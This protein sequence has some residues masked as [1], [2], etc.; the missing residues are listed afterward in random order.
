MT[1]PTPAQIE[2]AAKAIARKVGLDRNTRLIDWQQFEPDA[3]AAL[4][5]AAQV[6][7]V[8][9][10]TLD[11]LRT[12]AAGLLADGIDVSKLSNIGKVE[13][14]QAI[15]RVLALAAAQVGEQVHTVDNE[16]GIMG[17]DALAMDALK[18]ATIERC[19]QVVEQYDRE[20]GHTLN[21]DIAAAIRK[22]KDEP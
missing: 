4:T 1:A 6:G 15:D 3:K 16:F 5:A 9:G 19:A 11:D 10:E 20:R 12:I 14:R 17:G 21:A 18:N 22:L 13:L 2:A 7:P 8:P